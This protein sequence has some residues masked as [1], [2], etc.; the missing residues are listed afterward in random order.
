MADATFQQ[1]ILVTGGTGYVGGRLLSR[2]EDSGCKVRCMARRPENLVSRVA[3]TTEVVPGDVLDRD[4][5]DEAVRDVHTAYYLVHSMGTRSDFEDDDRRGAKN[6]A[7]A[8]QAAG[9][10]RI[11]YLGGLGSESDRLSKHLRSRHEVGDLLRES[12]AQVIEFRASITIGSGS[13]SFELVRSLVRKLPVM[14]WPKWVSTEAS[15][16]AVE[17]ILEYLTQVLIHPNGESK[18]YEIGG[19][20]RV[21]Y[22]GIMKEYARQRGL[23][24]LVIPVPFLSPWL[25]SLWLGLVTPVYA[26][27]GR[28]LIESLKNPTVVTD[29]S[30]LDD[31]DI[32]PRGF[33]EAITRA[34]SNEDH[35]I[36]ETRW[37]DSLSSAGPVTSWGGAKFRNRLMDSRTRDVELSPVEAFAPI[38]RIGG[39]T[40]WY[41][42]N[43]LWR[44]RGFL[45]LLVGGV[46]LR[47]RRNHPVD[48]AVGDALDFWRVEAF[49]PPKRLR[50]AAEMKLPGRAWLTF[51]VEELDNGGSRIRQTAEFDPVGLFGIAYWYT[52]WPL[53]QFV[54]TGMLNGIV[55][56][57]ERLAQQEAKDE[58]TSSA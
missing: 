47:R 22:G 34:L 28:K 18:V 7:L 25:S 56:E 12:G 6:F 29:F 57:G 38:Q 45:D 26:R 37:T 39:K 15:P 48:L 42:G 44:L 43:V 14:L 49:D 17:D 8:C 51:D 16:I 20:D 36:A 40:G 33:S 53:H 46:G 55:R 1:R 5:L 9:V 58:L 19:P 41:Y 52:I 35:E 11:I 21:S 50:L 30:A 13:L 23:R 4:S 10:R 31:F 27:I 54:F 32:Q 24:R 2:L 3:P